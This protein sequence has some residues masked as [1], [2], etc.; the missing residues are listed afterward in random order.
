MSRCSHDIIVACTGRT[1]QFA[2]GR[3]P[4]GIVTLSSLGGQDGA[5]GDR[6]K[7][8]PE[9]GNSMYKTTEA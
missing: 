4:R 5:A 7:G 3:P 6:R 2:C 9:R 1:A 8:I